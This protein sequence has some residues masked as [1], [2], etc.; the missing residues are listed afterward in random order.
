[1]A[2][3]AFIRVEQ[4]EKTLALDV[5]RSILVECVGPDMR[6]H[7]CNKAVRERYGLGDAELRGQLC[8]RA[9]HKRTSPCPGCPVV[10]ALENRCF[11]ETHM[12]SPDGRGWVA[13]A[14][15]IFASGGELLAAVWAATEVFV[16]HVA[17]QAAPVAVEG[18]QDLVSENR[19]AAMNVVSPD[20]D[21]IAVDPANARLLG[22]PVGELI[23]RKCY[24]EFEKRDAVCPYCPG[25]VALA[26]GRPHEAETEGYRVDGTR[27]YCRVRAQPVKGPAGEPVGFIE[28]V[29]DITQRKRAQRLA[30]IHERLQ[31]ALA[32]LVTDTEKA[33][34]QVLDVMLMVDEVDAG[35]V[36]RADPQTQQVAAVAQQGLEQQ[37][38]KALARLS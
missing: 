31:V 6:L 8:Y 20:F 10:K 4:A 29:E 2:H 15:P 28:L 17:K 38:V 30:L 16:G 7:W 13:A 26:T 19:E 36:F 33:L 3:L 24:E 12:L 22:K 1:M 9:I 32:N 11:A 23:G 37:C 27:F 5:M 18:L 34:A 14:S 35:C 21:L 25:V